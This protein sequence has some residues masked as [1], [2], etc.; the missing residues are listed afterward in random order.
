MNRKVV[1]TK[2]QEEFN[3]VIANISTWLKSEDWPEINSE[4]VVYIELGSRD[5]LHYALSCGDN[6]LSFQQW[7]DEYLSFKQGEYIVTLEINDFDTTCAK[8]N[9]CFKQRVT[10][11]NIEPWVDLFGGLLNGNNNLTFDKSE[12]LKD[13]R[14][15][16]KEEIAEYDRLGKPYDVTTLNKVEVKPWKPKLGE[17]VVFEP[18]LHAAGVTKGCWDRKM[19]LQVG[20]IDSD[21][22]RFKYETL[23]R[24]NHYKWSKDRL[25]PASNGIKCFRKALE[26]EIPKEIEE[27][28]EDCGGEGVRMV[29]KLYPNGHTEVNETCESCW[30]EGVIGNKLINT[31]KEYEVGEWVLLSGTAWGWG[32]PPE[33]VNNKILKITEIDKRWHSNNGGK[34]FF[35]G[36]A[37][38][39]K[40][41]VRRA[42]RDEI[43]KKIQL[44]VVR[45]C[46]LL[47]Q[48]P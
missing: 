47:L 48:L 43:N 26:Y 41:I 18:S 12:R 45:R 9:Y 25:F 36:A 22:L 4:T 35:D 24:Y 6:I 27:T 33:D 16:T 23:K 2:T 32:S 1:H 34:Y 10:K 11:T 42:T 7:K 46:P 14:Y 39:G 28:C 21:S 29:A 13:W 37:T 38:V 8:N 40:E 5:N 15:A 44:S 17:W 3:K 30:G 31:N 20:S 19:I